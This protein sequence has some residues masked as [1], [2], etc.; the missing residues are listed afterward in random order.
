L[1][2]LKEYGSDI[3]TELV[4]KSVK[5]IG[6]II[7]K[8]DKASKK[9]VEIISQIVNDGNEIGV[10]EAVIVAKDI[11]RKFPNKY[12]SLIKDLC[13]K[14]E[15]YNEPESKAS[16]IWIIGEYAEKIN[17]A[18]KL[19]DRFADTFIE[20]PDRVKLSLLTAAVKLY[21]KKPDEGEDI[22]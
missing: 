16:I 17:E 19:I 2:E 4:K 22:I 6:Q 7:L 13:S 21:L 18:E 14:L 9:A 1:A 3:D 20:D 15:D 10:Q 12:E 8:V 11:F 5:A